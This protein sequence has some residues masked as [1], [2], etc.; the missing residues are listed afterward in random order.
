M[1]TGVFG[2]LVS[3]GTKN[4]LNAALIALGGTP[5]CEGQPRQ[6]THKKVYE[7]F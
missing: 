2:P 7:T 6:I 3:G 4:G 5:F 1:I